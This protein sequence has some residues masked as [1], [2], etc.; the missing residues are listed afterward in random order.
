MVRLSK[1][2]TKKGDKGTTA[3][4]GGERVSKVDIRLEACGT[5][6]ELNSFVGVIRTYAKQCS[7]QEVMEETE[8]SLKQIQ[9]DLF[10]IGSLVATAP[11]SK[12]D[13]L[14]ELQPEHVA[15][16]EERMDEYQKI[17][18]PLPSFVLAGG[19][20]L[21]AHAHVARSV[22]RRAERILWKLN[23]EAP[24]AEV[25]LQYINRLSDY[26]FVY[27]RWVA[28]IAG[29]IEFLWETELDR[30]KKSQSQNVEE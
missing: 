1:I 2:Y 16:L 6:D 27:S 19:S 11:G 29:E 15:F 4:V 17:L 12:L 25:L 5:I 10:D 14:R 13:G 30:G 20:I 24:V 3:L 26:L 9:N 8:R 22:C 18:E 21:N 28:R 7:N 23:E